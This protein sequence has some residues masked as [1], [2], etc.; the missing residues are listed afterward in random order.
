MNFENVWEHLSYRTNPSDCIRIN[1]SQR[2]ALS[3]LL[4]TLQQSFKK[5][6]YLLFYIQ[7]QQR[8]IQN[9]VKQTRLGFYL[10]TTC[11]KRFILRCLTESRYY[12]KETFKQWIK[13]ICSLIIQF[14]TFIHYLFPNN[15]YKI[16]KI[17]I[18]TPWKCLSSFCFKIIRYFP[19]LTRWPL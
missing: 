14:E 5:L 10:L 7:R 17:Y 6:L 1:L 12:L 8:C 18:M 16:G 9:L 15:C 11:T 19:L 3:F 4:T 2:T 13:T